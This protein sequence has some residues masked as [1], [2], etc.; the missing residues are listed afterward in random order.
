MSSKCKHV[1]E[2]K[3][4][5]NTNEFR[6][7]AIHF[8][9]WGRYTLLEKGTEEYTA[10][11]KEENRKCMIGMTNSVGITITGVHYFYL[12][13]VRLFIFDYPTKYVSFIFTKIFQ[14]CERFNFSK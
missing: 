5:T 4:F 12:N 7:S 8:D 1:P 3:W 10:F 14:V 9:T 13:Y 2:V 6:E 11:W